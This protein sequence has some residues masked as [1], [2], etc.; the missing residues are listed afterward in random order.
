MNFINVRTLERQKFMS[1]IL[2]GIVSCNFR[3]LC[4]LRNFSTATLFN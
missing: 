2:L 4:F 1:T 3:S